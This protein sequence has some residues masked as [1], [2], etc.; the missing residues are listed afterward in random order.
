M[1]SDYTLQRVGN[2]GDYRLIG[3]ENVD[4]LD[5]FL[6][7]VNEATRLWIED[8][9]VFA[10]T[11]QPKQSPGDYNRF[12]CEIDADHQMRPM[13]VLLVYGKK[14]KSLAL[15][16]ERVLSLPDSCQDRVVE[17]SGL[18]GGASKN[19]IF[20]PMQLEKL[21]TVHVTRS[22]M[23]TCFDLSPQQAIALAKNNLEGIRFCS[24]SDKGKALVKYLE[25]NN[26]KRTLGVYLHQFNNAWNNIVTFLSR[27]PYPVFE[28]LFFD[29]CHD[30]N[31]GCNALLVQANVK[32]I[33]VTLSPNIIRKSKAFEP[34]LHALYDGTL[35]SPTLRVCFDTHDP[36]QDENLHF[37]ETAIQ[38]LFIA[39]SSAKCQL[40]ELHLQ[41]AHVAHQD[42]LRLIVEEYLP[43]MLQ[44]NKSLETLGIEFLEKLTLDIIAKHP[45][46]RNIVFVP[47]EEPTLREYGFLREWYPK[48]PSHHIWFEHMTT[49]LP[50]EGRRVVTKCPVKE[51]QKFVFFCQFKRLR[52]VKNERVRSHL[53]VAALANHS[54]SP[55]QIYFLLSG[56]QDILM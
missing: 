1:T 18:V 25:H 53:L 30:T 22:Y 6:N 26:E 24:I 15:A 52:R 42:T 20:L 55:Q 36:D 34:L 38:A 23:F 21:L 32:S 9:K 35:V 7:E 3:L 29:P 27:S 45:R 5:V 28:E 17:F 31:A 39:I 13:Q 43:R 44:L 19:L 41:L 37:Y 47:F 46:L 4:S 2:K 40:K 56:N 33:A 8:L 16:V 51:W 11:S 49:I 12:K 10:M 14:V 54:N 50:H 48:H